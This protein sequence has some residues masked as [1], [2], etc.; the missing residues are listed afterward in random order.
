MLC[1]KHHSPKSSSLQRGHG[2]GGEDT[3]TTF[4]DHK[5]IA[6]DRVNPS[7]ANENLF[8]DS[9]QDSSPSFQ[10]TR[11]ISDS[12]PNVKAIRQKGETPSDNLEKVK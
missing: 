1:T 6:E 9:S 7:P 2:Q 8:G 11:C 4:A 3:K 12:L 10:D 5:G